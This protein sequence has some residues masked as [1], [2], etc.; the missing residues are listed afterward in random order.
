MS[1]YSSV[2][3]IDGPSGSGK[4]TIAR[5]V[6]EKLG[7]LYIDTGAMF[8]AIA[9]HFDSKN[10]DRNDIPA[11]EKELSEMK[12]EY[13]VNAD[14][15]IKINGDDLSQKIR[16]HH[17]SKLASQYSQIPVVRTFLKEFQ[18]ELVASNHSVMEGRDI[19]T[20]V[21]PKAYCKI[22]LTASSE[23]RA[24]RR[25]AQLEEKGETGHSYEQILA[26]IIKRDEDDS[27]RSQAPLKL[28][29]DSHEVDTSNLTIDEVAEKIISISQN[30]QSRL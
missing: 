29:T 5:L 17:V 1:E 6:A 27:N 2:L 4:S 14:Y 20:V 26:D 16:E 23:E 12:L 19:G 8:R 21:F 30:L 7:I 15:L 28:A 10:I 24:K 25:L 3:A 18:R 9:L 22:F 13:G 11:I